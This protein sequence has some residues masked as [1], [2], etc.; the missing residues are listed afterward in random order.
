MAV[1]VQAGM[2]G[3]RNEMDRIV[4]KALRRHVRLNG[5]RN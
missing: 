1:T 5:R 2:I 4:S 3:N